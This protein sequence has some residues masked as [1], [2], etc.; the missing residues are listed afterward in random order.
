MKKL[1]FFTSFNDDRNMEEDESDGEGEPEQNIFSQI[2]GDDSSREKLGAKINPQLASMMDQLL[3]TEMSP[4]MAKEKD[5]SYLRPKNVEFASPHKVNLPVWEVMNKWTR[6]SDVKLQNVQKNVLK[7]ALPIAKVMEKLY[8][9]KDDPENLD[10]NL[11]ISTL[12]D[13]V[14]FIGSA[15]VELVKIRKDQIKRD[16]PKNMH[17]LCAESENF[18]PGLLFGD[19]LKTKV[20]EVSELNKIKNKF[21][22]DNFRGKRGMLR[23]RGGRYTNSYRGFQKGNRFSPYPQKNFGSKFSKNGPSPKNSSNKA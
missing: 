19:D 3:K 11:L 17:G 15:N 13:S 22:N 10:I 7:S 4:D 14:N 21:G 1:S 16:L 8:E 9:R 20:K 12:A 2:S 5:S 18:S 6:R 23:G